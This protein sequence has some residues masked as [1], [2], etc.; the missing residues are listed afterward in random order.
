MA[1]AGILICIVLPPWSAGKWHPDLLGRRIYHAEHSWRGPRSESP[2]KLGYGTQM[3]TTGCR[4]ALREDETW[5]PDHLG[6]ASRNH[7][8]RKTVRRHR[9][10]GP[11]LVVFAACKRRRPVSVRRTQIKVSRFLRSSCWWQVPGDI[12]AL[13]GVSHGLSQDLGRAVRGHPHDS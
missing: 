12:V 3:L 9:P 10:R 4:G 1:Y 7:L 8:W 11:S 2:A 6:G 5:G 13:H